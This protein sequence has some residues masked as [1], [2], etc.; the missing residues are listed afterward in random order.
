VLAQ[1]DP[2]KKRRKIHAIALMFF[3]APISHPSPYRLPFVDITPVILRS[4]ELAM[5]R[6]LPTPLKIASIM[7]WLFLP[8][9]VLIWSVMPPWFTKALKNSSIKS[10]SNKPTFFLF[11]PGW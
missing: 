11:R 7:W 5:F 10:K 4:K 9:I 6:D 8:Y 2:R 3:L 1:P